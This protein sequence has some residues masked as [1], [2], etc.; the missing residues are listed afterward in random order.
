MPNSEPPGEVPA[1]NVSDSQGIQVGTGNTQYNAWV[2][3]QPLDPVALSGLN[4]HV[5]VA[6]L[7]Q[8]PHD[9]LV[10]FF[11]RAKPGDVSE[12]LGALHEV[13]VGKFAVVLA[14]ISRRKA[15]ELMEH[16]SLPQAYKVLP[17]ASEAIARE[18]ARLRWTGAG[19]MHVWD[20]LCRFAREYNDG[21]IFWSQESG[22]EITTGSIDKWLRKRYV[23]FATGYQEYSLTS[24]SGESGIRQVFQGGTV[25]SSGL[26]TF[27]VRDDSCYDS[28][29][30]SGSWLGF[31]IE[32]EVR[33][34][35]LG[36]M[37]RF[38][39]GTVY[40]RTHYEEYPARTESFAVEAEMAS[41]MSSDR[42]FRPTSRAKTAS[43]SSGLFQTTQR[44][45]IEE[46]W[47]TSE[48][49]VYWDGANKPIVV[50]PQIWDYYSKLGA[51][52]SWLGFPINPSKTS[53][54]AGSVQ[55]DFEQGAIYSLPA[56]GPHAVPN[57]VRDLI[58]KDYT[59]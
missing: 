6:R 56:I 8:L 33:N 45:E 4:P 34:G 42:T 18:A 7:Q 28:E 9:E 22:F 37:Q 55:Q 48:T 16:S 31:P 52:T 25:Y 59:A 12:I 49:A 51:E 15:T 40:T 2:P 17:E 13:D 38:E 54:W 57:A 14:D 41:I 50:D 21:H 35:S 11:A 19:A 20:S 46:E 47:G 10:D 32:E 30:A 36:Q 5:A 27:L 24:R 1:V 23:M 29:G 58:R 44:F 53:P 3:K 43:S 26:G 39:A